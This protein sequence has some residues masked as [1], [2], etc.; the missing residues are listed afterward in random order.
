MFSPK[1][2]DRIDVEQQ[3]LKKERPEVHKQAH[4]SI[5]R[6]YEICNTIV[7]LSVRNERIRAQKHE[8]KCDNT[9]RKPKPLRKGNFAQ[10]A[11]ILDRA[12]ETGQNSP[13]LGKTWS[14]STSKSKDPQTA[15]K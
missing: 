3:E 11:K 10:T 1:K 12:S 15:F 6:G 9:H 4:A 5:R 13:G 7:V 14:G 2:C 8:E